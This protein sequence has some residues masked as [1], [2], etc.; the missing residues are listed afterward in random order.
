MVV[1][2]YTVS[3]VLRVVPRKL[4]VLSFVLLADILLRSVA[5]AWLIRRHG[6]TVEEALAHLRSCR[7][8]VNPNPGFTRQL[9]E[10]RQACLERKL[11]R[12]V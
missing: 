3:W 7:A 11:E 12:S 2:R 5:A 4:G 8:V 6:W 1:S 10:W 9:E